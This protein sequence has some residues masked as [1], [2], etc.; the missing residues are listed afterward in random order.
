MLPI[1]APSPPRWAFVLYHG[2]DVPLWHKRLRLGALEGPLDMREIVLT[3]DGD[4]YGEIFLKEHV[5]VAAVRLSPSAWPPPLGISRQ[6]V[7]RFPREPNS[8]ELVAIMAQARELARDVWTADHGSIVPERDVLLQ[9]AVLVDVPPATAVPPIEPIESPRSV[10]SEGLLG[11]LRA[12]R[13]GVQEDPKPYAGFVW[14]LDEDLP[15][16]W[17]RSKFVTL[18]PSSFGDGHRAFGPTPMAANYKG[19][20]CYRSVDPDGTPRAVERNAHILLLKF[21]AQGERYRVFQEAVSIMSTD[22]LPGGFGFEG[23]RTLLPLLKTFVQQGGSPELSHM[24]WKRI[25]S[26]PAGDRAVYEDESLC[27]VLQYLITIDQVNAPN[28]KGRELIGRRIQL[29][30]ETHLISP[31]APDFSSLVHFMGWGRRRGGAAAQQSLTSYVADQFRTKASI[32][33]ESRKAREEKKTFAP[34][35]RL[36]KA[37]A[38]ERAR[39]PDN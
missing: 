19:L 24:E 10:V 22:E 28:L 7:Y 32:A 21:D 5:D 39:A 11:R 18:P 16:D 26:V 31:S 33:K 37:K 1:A 25:S 17:K 38:R 13:G 2:P 20:I 34:I 14:V 23:P 30:R 29:I 8:A 27:L 12:V 36:P 35:V 15:G 3:P 6:Q 9:L 4:I